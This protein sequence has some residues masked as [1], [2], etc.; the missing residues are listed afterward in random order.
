MNSFRVSLCKMSITS[1]FFSYRAF[2]Q[3]YQVRSYFPT[4]V[5]SLSSPLLS[6][7]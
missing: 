3:D 5:L 6:L 1:V 7:S 2:A 4:F